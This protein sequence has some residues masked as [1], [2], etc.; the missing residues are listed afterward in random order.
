MSFSDFIKGKRDCFKN[1]LL[2]NVGKMAYA[3]LKLMWLI[4][5]ST[6]ISRRLQGI[7]GMSAD[8]VESITEIRGTLKFPVRHPG[9][10][11]TTRLA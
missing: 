4:R 5:E 9:H 7:E 3:K 8:C 6:E 11:L 1:Q 2:H 10:S